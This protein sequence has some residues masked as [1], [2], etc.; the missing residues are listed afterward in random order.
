[1]I[2]S[3]NY[4]LLNLNLPTTYNIIIHA[5]PLF[6]TLDNILFSK[7]LLYLKINQCFCFKIQPKNLFQLQVIKA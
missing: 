4:K 5:T 6:D 3:L 1:M 7:V 2:K